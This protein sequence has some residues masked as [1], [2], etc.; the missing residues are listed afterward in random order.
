M[1]W[2]FNK[3]QC[4]RCHCCRHWRNLHHI[5]NFFLQNTT[6]RTKYTMIG[7]MFKTDGYA[8]VRLLSYTYINTL[9]R[10]LKS[11][12][13]AWISSSFE[14]IVF[15]FFFLCLSQRFTACTR[16]FKGNSKRN[17]VRTHEE[18]ETAWT[19]L[20]IRD[21]GG[22]AEREPHCPLRIGEGVE[23]PATTFYKP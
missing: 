13:H 3:R 20:Q 8:F 15:F 4:K 1:L 14:Y 22:G 21:T 23:V 10:T 2:S 12:Y 19:V 6:A 17:R 5:L 11:L 16:C 9:L 18:E 7:P